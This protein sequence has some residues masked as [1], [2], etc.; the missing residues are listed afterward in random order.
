MQENS[1]EQI[2]SFGYTVLDSSSG[3][4]HSR[5]EESDDA[6]SVTGSYEVEYPGCIIRRVDYNADESNGFQVLSVTRRSCAS[7]E[8]I[9]E[10]LP[11]E[12]WDKQIFGYKVLPSSDTKRKT[13]QAPPKRIVSTTLGQ[14]FDEH[15]TLDPFDYHGNTISRRTPSITYLG[16]GKFVNETFYNYGNQCN[17]ALDYKY[18][19]KFI[20]YLY[21]MD[22]KYIN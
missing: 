11:V 12:H 10:D 5:K 3:T 6:G 14:I 18:K 13:N 2:Y 1:G 8:I 21:I 20:A 19:Q 4:S 17:H 7:G 15:V 9:S 22:Q 16:D